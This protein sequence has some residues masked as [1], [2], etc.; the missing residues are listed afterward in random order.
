MLDA[1]HFNFTLVEFSF[2]IRRLHEAAHLLAGYNFNFY[3]DHAW[4]GDFPGLVN[5]AIYYLFCSCVFLAF[6][7]RFFLL[8]KYKKKYR[9]NAA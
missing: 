8:P 5:R 6:L 4:S 3:K 1:H 2:V 9:K 7:M